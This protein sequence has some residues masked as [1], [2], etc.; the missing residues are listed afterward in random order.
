MAAPTDKKGGNYFWELSIILASFIQ[1]LAT[2]TQPIR[3]LVFRAN[4]AF[5]EIKN[6]LIKEEGPVLKY[7]DVTK[8]NTISCNA[9]PASL[10]GVLL[11]EGSP[12][13]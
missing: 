4:K 6:L 3:K 11:Q 9:T 5:Q 2:V 12:V 13:A 7:C 10:G 8:P 1:N